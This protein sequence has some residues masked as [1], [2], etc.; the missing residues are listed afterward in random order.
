MKYT[1]ALVGAA[2]A[3]AASSVETGIQMLEKLNSMDQNIENVDYA[4]TAL[5]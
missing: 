4:K 3:D 5:T 1:L 2:A